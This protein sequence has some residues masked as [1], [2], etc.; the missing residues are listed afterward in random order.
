MDRQNVTNVLVVL[1]VVIVVG[2]VAWLKSA[3]T[4]PPVEKD[5]QAADART[6]YS[7]A[8]ADRGDN[9]RAPTSRPATSEHA[10][11]TAPAPAD[12]TATEMPGPGPQTQAAP[13]GPA[14]PAR[15]PRMIDLGSDECIPCKKM[16]PILKK[17]ETE[18]AGR[19]EIEFIDVKKN[20]KAGQQYGIRLIPTQIF[21]DRDGKE[22]WR[23]VGFLSREEI[24]AKLKELGA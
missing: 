17:L 12:G 13:P 16:A 15:L 8:A 20:R 21:Y 5:P 2:G 18:Y 1:A 10:T 11:T 14:K 23:H 6:G 7:S 19:A 24:V 4:G 9:S 22:V 3:Q